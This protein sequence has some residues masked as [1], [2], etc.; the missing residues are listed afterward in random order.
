VR[1]IKRAVGAGAGRPLDQ[2][3]AREIE[4]YNALFPT[5]DRIEGVRAWRDRRPPRFSGE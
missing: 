1:A 2:G 3:M 5:S 4:A